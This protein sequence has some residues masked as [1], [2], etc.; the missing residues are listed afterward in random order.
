MSSRLGSE[1]SMPSWFMA[2]PSQMPMVPNSKGTPPAM[3]T[4]ALTASVDLA[5]VH[6]ARHDLAE[7]VGDADERT[8]H[9][10]VADAERAQQ[11]TVR[12]ARHATLDL[13]T[14]HDGH[15]GRL[16]STSARRMRGHRK[17]WTRND[18]VQSV[19]RQ[20]GGSGRRPRCGR[21]DERGLPAMTQCPSCD[22]PLPEGAVFCPACGAGLR[23]V[24]PSDAEVT[25][26]VE[27][28]STRVVGA[29]A[30]EPIDAG[31]TQAIDPG[32]THAIDATAQLA[33]THIMAPAASS[34]LCPGCG[35]EAPVD[36]AFCTRCGAAR[37]EEPTVAL[38]AAGGQCAACGATLAADMRFCP[39]CGARRGEP[40][41]AESREET[42]VVPGAATDVT[43][44][45]APAFSPAP[46]PPPPPPRPVAETGAGSSLPQWPHGG[47][48][49]SCAGCGR[50]RRFQRL[51]VRPA[52]HRAGRPPSL[53]R[54]GHAD[55]STR[56]RCTGGSATTV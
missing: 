18:T 43:R 25:H 38:P 46:P 10:G 54:A 33:E 41:T 32:V 48:R 39:Q 22:R 42:L 12:R 36:D 2:R 15:L 52:R 4:P 27:A 17:P 13:V 34:W 40:E 53:R 14:P 45:A 55:P 6:V 19:R 35:A 9:L 5:Q 1:Y 47:H 16:W 11:G 7:G 44:V 8:F 56:R 50:R 31:V 28:A 23:A 21:P 3:R 20:A 37:P 26:D 51:V 49:G 30:T 24:D 29:E